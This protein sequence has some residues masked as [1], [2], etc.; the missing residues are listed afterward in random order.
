MSGKGSRYVAITRQ[1][2][3]QFLKSIRK[4]FSLKSGTKGIYVIQLSDNVGLAVNSTIGDEVRGLGKASIKLNFVSLHSQKF[5]KVI[6]GYKKIMARVVK[7]KYLQ[8]STNWRN[9]LKDAIDKCIAYYNQGSSWFEKIALPDDM[10]QQ[11]QQPVVDTQLLVRI[12]SIPNWDKDQYLSSFHDQVSKGR[13]LSQKQLAIIQ[14]QEQFATRNQQQTQA[15]QFP[16]APS[17]MLVQPSAEPPNQNGRYRKNL[18]ALR[19]LYVALERKGASQENLEEIGEIGKSFKSKGSLSR[20]EIEILDEIC[21]EERVQIPSFYWIGKPNPKKL[22]SQQRVSGQW[23]K[24]QV[25]N[26]ISE[27]YYRG[28]PTGSISKVK[29]GYEAKINVMGRD[30]SLGVFKTEDQAFNKIQKEK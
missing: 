25:G 4:P 26:S 7:K 6:Y 18:L 8:R 27:V 28:I 5:H 29:K 1:E 23:N 22:A 11:P 13:T 14:R 30:K 21:E 24:V 3:E 2:F 20:S 16:N 10:Q 15:P 12:E 9:T 19:D 17:D